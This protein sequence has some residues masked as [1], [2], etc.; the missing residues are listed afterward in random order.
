LSAR[1][2]KARYHPNSDVLHAELGS[3]P[4]QVWRGIHEGMGVLKQGLITRIGD[5]QSTNVWND[6]WIPRNGM[7]RPVCCKESNAPV[8]AKDFIDTTC[9]SWDER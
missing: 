4:S 5:G 8:L 1:I 9:A 3:N 2:V 6:N 7:L